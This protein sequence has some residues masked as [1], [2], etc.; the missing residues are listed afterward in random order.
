MVPEVYGDTGWG[1]IPTGGSITI[2]ILG[3]NERE[4][5]RI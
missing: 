2:R 1:G 4:S 5:H 3:G